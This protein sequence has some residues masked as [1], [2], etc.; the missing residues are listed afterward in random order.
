MWDSSPHSLGLTIKSFAHTSVYYVQSI[1]GKWCCQL[2]ELIYAN[3]EIGIQ[4]KT[5]KE[6]LYFTGSENNIYS[7]KSVKAIMDP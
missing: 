7:F 3:V 5:V 1:V 4:A 2:I 6:I